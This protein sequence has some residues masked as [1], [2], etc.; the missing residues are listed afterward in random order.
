MSMHQIT[1]S[2]L[3][4]ICAPAKQYPMPE[5]LNTLYFPHLWEED[6]LLPEWDLCMLDDSFGEHL[7]ALEAPLVVPADSVSDFG[8]VPVWSRVDMLSV[9]PLCI[10]VQR[11]HFLDCQIMGRAHEYQL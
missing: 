6:S 1:D 2:I 3:R 11:Y 5:L 7:A 9:H 10:A 8:S 4:I